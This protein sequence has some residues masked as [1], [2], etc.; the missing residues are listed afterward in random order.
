[1]SDEE[2]VR[3]HELDRQ[4]AN[5]DIV[6]PTA[7]TLPQGDEE[8]HE[9]TVPVE[10][11]ENRGAPQDDSPQPQQQLTNSL[12]TA[13]SQGAEKDQYV[14]EGDFGRQRFGDN[15][16]PRVED[17]ADQRNEETLQPAMAVVEEALEK[18]ETALGEGGEERSQQ[19][20][21]GDG[22]RGCE[23]DEQDE[24]SAGPQALSD[25]DREAILRRAFGLPPREPSPAPEEP[26][27]P[28]IDIEADLAQAESKASPQIPAEGEPTT[29]PQRPDAAPN[30]MPTLQKYFTEQGEMLSELY[31]AVERVGNGIEQNAERRTEELLRRLDSSSRACWEELSEH[32]N[33]LRHDWF[34]EAKRHHQ[35]I[36][37]GVADI[38]GLIGEGHLA[39]RDQVTAQTG[40]LSSKVHGLERALNQTKEVVAKISDN[41]AELLQFQREE[42]SRREADW[43]RLVKLK[44]DRKLQVPGSGTKIRLVVTIQGLGEEQAAVPGT[45]LLVVAYSN[46]YVSDLIGASLRRAMAARIVPEDVH[47]TQCNLYLKNPAVLL[48]TEDALDDVGVIEG[49]G[50]RLEVGIKS[51]SP[52]LNVESIRSQPQQL[53]QPAA[54]APL[55]STAP[56][57][58]KQPTTVVA[59]PPAQ[60]TNLSSRP[61]LADVVLEEDAARRLWDRQDLERRLIVETSRM[62]FEPL[63]G[64]EKRERV[65]V[66]KTNLHAIR[67]RLVDRCTYGANETARMAARMSL[68]KLNRVIENPTV[69]PEQMNAARRQAEMALSELDG[70][71]GES[72][73]VQMMQE[74]VANE[75]SRKQRVIDELKDAVHFV[76]HR[77]RIPDALFQRAE[78]LVSKANSAII[79]AAAMSREELQ[80]VLNELQ[81]FVN[82]VQGT[83]KS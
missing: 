12:E 67:L 17:D 39:L 74:A 76:N 44:E 20:A 53:S 33:Q 48:F 25:A 22:N 81:A 68:E 47:P 6:A 34:A 61:D 75:E 31:S 3:E 79:M 8:Q 27:S 41:V 38:Q 45:D 24:G 54:K 63:V 56:S 60:S 4:D 32:T 58:A 57:A 55:V 28:E 21:E 50:L 14:E 19:Q 2:R 35:E 82:S 15:S 65:A 26:G 18:P 72:S 29:A 9:Q 71:P 52:K 51:P 77:I 37:K 70:A 36:S 11:T 59:A 7:E 69:T 40:E 13:D 42:Q 80:L 64:A 78:D 62:E 73:R 66:A 5:P 49:T 1:M 30:V 23:G 46:D 43:L 83:S 10:A 16:E